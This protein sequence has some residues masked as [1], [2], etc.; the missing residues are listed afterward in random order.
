MPSVTASVQHSIDIPSHF[1]KT[2]NKRCPF[3]R[4]EV[5]LSYVDGMI[6]IGRTD[7]EA[8]ILWPPDVKN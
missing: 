4:K 7:A 3:E 5:N 2:R 1:K 6:L 8:P